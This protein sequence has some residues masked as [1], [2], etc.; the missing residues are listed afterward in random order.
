MGK[1]RHYAATT[2]TTSFTVAASFSL[3]SGSG[4]GSSSGTATVAPGAATSFTLTL[5]PGGAATYS[6]ALTFSAT[7]LPRRNRDLLSFNH[8]GGQRGNAGHAHH[9]DQQQPDGAQRE[10]LFGWTFAPGSTGILAAAVGRH[11]DGAQATAA[12]TASGG[13]AGRNGSI[14][15]RFIGIERLW[16]K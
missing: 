12:D 8:S 7:G 13:S 11:E 5:L 6:D 3:T 9:P 10:A 2:A 1:A 16:G 15:G 4:T 14:P